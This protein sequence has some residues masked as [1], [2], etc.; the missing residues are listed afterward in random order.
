MCS[1]IRYFYLG[2]LSIQTHIF[3]SYL[4]DLKRF[5]IMTCLQIRLKP[6]I[7]QYD[8]KLSSVIFCFL[9]DLSCEFR[10]LKQE[11]LFIFFVHKI[12]ELNHLLLAKKMY[13]LQEFRIIVKS[14]GGYEYTL[15]W[16]F[17]KLLYHKE[18]IQDRHRPKVKP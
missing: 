13:L 14:M 6:W 5:L 7:V 10:V 17:W 3:A 8:G 2:H 11:L 1:T 9:I 4:E 16:T 18:I 12:I 15:H